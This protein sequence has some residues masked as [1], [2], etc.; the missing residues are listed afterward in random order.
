MNIRYNSWLLWFI[1]SYPFRKTYTANMCGHKTKRFGPVFDGEN[2][3]GFV[4]LP[5][6]ENGKPD[7]CHKCIDEMAIRCAW[8]GG[9]IEVGDPVTLCSPVNEKQEM[10]EYAVPYGDD[11]KTFVGCLRWECGEPMCRSGFWQ[12]PGV[13]RRVP[14]PLE[15]CLLGPQGSVVFVQDIGD[16]HNLGTVTPLE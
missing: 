11:G 16:P 7:H 5:L 9:S 15:L 3:S 8:C 10:P 2:R 14:S 6:A 4:T 1:L 12:P 13:V